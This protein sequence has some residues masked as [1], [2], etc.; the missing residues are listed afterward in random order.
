MSLKKK[1]SIFYEVRN[2][3]ESWTNM[4]QEESFSGEK[5]ITSIRRKEIHFFFLIGVRLVIDMHFLSVIA[6]SADVKVKL[7]ISRKEAFKKAIG[8]LHI[9]VPYYNFI[10]SNHVY[11]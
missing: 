8:I 7:N 9:R 11:I 2:K 4:P 10:N 1:T 5:H 3:R 6:A